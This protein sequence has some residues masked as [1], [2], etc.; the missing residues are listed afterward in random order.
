MA[1]TRDR[2]DRAGLSRGPGRS[3]V[4][5]VRVECGPGCQVYGF[6]NE[7]TEGRSSVVWVAGGLWKGWLNG[8]GQSAGPR[9]PVGWPSVSKSPLRRPE[10]SSSWWALAG[11]GVF[12]VTIRF[13]GRVGDIRMRTSHDWYAYEF[14]I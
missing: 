3:R 5:S 7:R 8:G 13:L 12:G 6:K 1:R 14:Q 9:A 4:F 2:V 10:I 11:A